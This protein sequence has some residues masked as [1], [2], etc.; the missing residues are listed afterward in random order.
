[1]PAITST[2]GHTRGMFLTGERIF[3]DLTLRLDQ[4]FN[5]APA[6]IVKKG[7]RIMGRDDVMA[8]RLHWSG[9]RIDEDRA[10]RLDCEADD[11]AVL[12]VD[13]SVFAQHPNVP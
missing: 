2:C 13:Q 4:R 7:T 10:E 1:M 12:D 6:L 9:W 11:A 8:L 5:P 3:N